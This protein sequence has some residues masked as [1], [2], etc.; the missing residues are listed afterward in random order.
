MICPLAKA[1]Y[2]ILISLLPSSVLTY[3]TSLS[4]GLI[5]LLYVATSHPTPHF[6]SGELVYSRSRGE[7]VLL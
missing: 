4:F 7:I 5:L 2:N 1:I 6:T 3:H